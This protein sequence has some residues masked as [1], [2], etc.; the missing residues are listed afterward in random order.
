MDQGSAG[1]IRGPL[2][3]YFPTS[4]RDYPDQSQ[5]CL[6]RRISLFSSGS[7]AGSF[8]KVFIARSV[9]KT[10]TVI[11]RISKTRARI[12]RIIL[13]QY[14]QSRNAHHIHFPESC[15]TM[16]S[17]GGFKTYR[18]HPTQKQPNIDSTPQLL[19]IWGTFFRSC[20]EA[21]ASPLI[22]DVLVLWC[23]FGMIVD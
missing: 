11:R 2:I 12:L 4:H 21:V 15:T 3:R 6:S 13:I 17:G 8:R 18:H 20:L 19:Q 9:M 1:I 22:R 5:H 10:I 23:R 14:E 16:W 7:W